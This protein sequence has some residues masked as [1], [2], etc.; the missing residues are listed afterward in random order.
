LVDPLAKCGLLEVHESRA[1]VGVLVSLLTAGLLASKPWALNPGIC[2][3]LA[4]HMHTHS[5]THHHWGSGHQ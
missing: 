3:R 1:F 4:T 2:M 5:S